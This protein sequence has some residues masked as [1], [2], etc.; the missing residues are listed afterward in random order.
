[1]S[2]DHSRRTWS[3]V[4]AITILVFGAEALL[5]ASGCARA[6]ALRAV[7]IAPLPADT[8][9]GIPGLT[10]PA[11]IVTDRN[12]IVH[13]RVANLADLYRAWGFVHARDRLWQMMHTR[14]SARGDLWRWF[15]NRAL[16]GDG[17]AQLFEIASRVDRIWE[18]ES[19]DSTQRAA[20]EAYAAGVNAYLDLC[21]SGRVAWP[22]ELQRLAKV[23]DPWR[24]QDSYL[25]LFGM[26]F[27]LDFDLPELR[28][29]GELERDGLDAF[30]ARRR[31]EEDFVYATIPDGVPPFPGAGDTSRTR[32][33]AMLP[34][35]EP[36]GYASNVF[37]VGPLRSASGRPLFAN[38]PHLPLATPATFHVIHVTCDEESVD[39]AGVAVPG[40][41]LIASGRNRTCAWGVTTLS[42]DVM[43]VYA[44]TLSPDHRRVKGPNGWE[45][46]REQPFTMRFR[47]GPLELPTIGQKRRFSPHGPIVS[48]DAKRH[49]AYSVRWAV[50][51]THVTLARLLGLE[52]SRTAAEVAARGRTIQTPNFNLA[53]ADVG[54]HVR[55]QTIGGMPLRGFVA[56]PGPIPGD[57]RHEWLGQVGPDS[58][59][60]W[61][62]PASGFLVNGNNLPTRRAVEPLQR[63][64]W[65]QERAIRMAERLAGDPRV[66]LEDMRSVQ[67]DVVSLTARRL[68][69]VMLRQLDNA[70]EL[71]AR[72][73]AAADTLRRWDFACYKS[74][75]APTLFRAWYGAFQRRWNLEGLNGL[76]AAA[77]GGRA[78]E[79]LADSTG[80]PEAVPGA[81]R[82]ALDTALT[83]LEAMMGPDLSTWTWGRAHRAR[84][85]HA[86]S[87]LDPE[88]TPATVAMDG[89]NV[90]PSVGRSNLPWDWKVTHGPVWR[91]LVD[92][93]NPDRSW[94]VVAPGN[95]SEGPQRTALADEWAHHGY[96][97]LDLR[98]DRIDRNRGG[99][100]TLTPA[101]SPPR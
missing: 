32:P 45:P 46:V 67:S 78:P 2:P 3:V 18:R 97:P 15:G 50:D 7:R 42:A 72:E 63:Y 38:D 49:V 13:V 54:G 55:Y 47:A 81:V 10:A 91:H 43:D 26:S 58:L 6:P 21:R 41:P 40:L 83:R 76:T 101:A 59:P 37:A 48:I 90:T 12:G 88:L 53:S 14:Q 56:E 20:L 19:R 44:D 36:D 51:D 64:G 34:A 68:V 95:P 73:R 99:E 94:C 98:W 52:R 24:P 8:T 23:P 80:T 9:L 82:A 93:A 22:V 87:W 4:I 25:V 31:F 79:A 84:F 85:A 96:V 65:L 16:R 28:E 100:L 35:G 1:M 89:D 17:G 71:N 86:L 57:G 30:R 27:V 61:D 11:R 60:A 62:V 75:V 5:L 69:P 70:G 92:L 33:V 74:R 39:A 77:L 29:Q 66:T